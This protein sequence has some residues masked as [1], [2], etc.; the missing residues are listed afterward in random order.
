MLSS[1]IRRINIMKMTI[2]I[3]TICKIEKYL[4]LRTSR[5]VLHPKIQNKKPKFSCNIISLTAASHLH[6]WE[7]RQNDA[8]W[9]RNKWKQCCI[10][11]GILVLVNC[12]KVAK[13]FF[14]RCMS[15]FSKTE[16]AFVHTHVI[17]T[18]FLPTWLKKQLHV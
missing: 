4:T 7:I 13:T 1:W 17:R 11:Y 16:R 2:L 8:M 12:P 14:K 10:T 6:K 18:T 5:W 3:K 15:T 9:N